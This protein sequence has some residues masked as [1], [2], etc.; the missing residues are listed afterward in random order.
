M[1]I[2]NNSELST[3]FQWISPKKV[4]TKLHWNQNHWNELISEVSTKFQWINPKNVPT[5]LHGNQ[6]L[7]CNYV[8]QCLISTPIK[9]KVQCLA[10]MYYNQ[11]WCPVKWLITVFTDTP[12]PPI[13]T[14]GWDGWMGQMDGTD[15]WDGSYK[16]MLRLLEHR[17]RMT[18]PIL[19]QNIQYWYFKSAG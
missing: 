5:K 17:F 13:S 10:E 12:L 11:L 18:H 1:N 8:P 4:P 6:N 19:T 7:V 15:G 16:W 3:K 14:P 9:Q 2:V